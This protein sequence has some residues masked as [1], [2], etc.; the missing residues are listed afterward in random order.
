M[1]ERT[2]LILMALVFAYEIAKAIIAA[3]AAPEVVCPAPV[4]APIEATEPASPDPD[5]STSS[6][7]V[8]G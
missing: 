7:G 2:F 6:T 5:P 1:S 3:P 4:T 8:G